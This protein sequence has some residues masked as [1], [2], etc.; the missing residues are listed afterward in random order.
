MSHV[1]GE[2]QGSFFCRTGRRGCPRGG[3]VVRSWVRAYDGSSTYWSPCSTMAYTCSS[4]SNLTIWISSWSCCFCCARRNLASSCCCWYLS[5]SCFNR[6][7]SSCRVCCLR[8]AAA[9]AAN[10]T[11]LAVAIVLGL[12]ADDP[13]RDPYNEDFDWFDCV[14]DLVP[15]LLTDP[16]ALRFR[17]PHS[18][19]VLY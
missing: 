16:V 14:R 7:S 19:K 18:R 9:S 6:N 11:F 2:G 3:E 17:C 15:A 1:G 5:A 4:V 12:K 8:S 10:D 13:P